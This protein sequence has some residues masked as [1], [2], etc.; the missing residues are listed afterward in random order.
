VVLPAR[1]H[2]AVARGAWAWKDCCCGQA[3]CHR[4]PAACAPAS[5]RP[6]GLG[7]CASIAHST[8]CPPHATQPND[9]ALTAAASSMPTPA[10]PK[11]LCNACGV[12]LGRE[13]AKA[14]KGVVPKKKKVGGGVAVGKVE[15]RRWGG[16]GQGRG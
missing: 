8:Q 6:G 4:P 1:V 15:G 13:R 7:E 3:S 10:G 9:P 16:C 14:N 2:A 12:R 5:N 11:T